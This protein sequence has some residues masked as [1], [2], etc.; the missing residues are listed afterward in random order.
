MLVAATLLVAACSGGTEE[1]IPTSTTVETTSTTVETTSTTSA[2]S[3]T[4]TTV[5]STTTTVPSVL[6]MPLTGQPIADE[7]EIPD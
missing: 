3:T 1:A 5:P 6:R 7:S 2:T 4:S